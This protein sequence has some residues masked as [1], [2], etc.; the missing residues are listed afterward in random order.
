[1]PFVAAVHYAISSEAAVNKSAPIRRHHTNQTTA[2]NQRIISRRHDE[3]N[4]M[5]FVS[6][7]VLLLLL[8]LMFNTE[9]EYADVHCDDD[10]GTCWELQHYYLLFIIMYV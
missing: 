10:V 5:H 9:S 8:L 3:C 6:D 1:M 7:T 2:Q 4:W